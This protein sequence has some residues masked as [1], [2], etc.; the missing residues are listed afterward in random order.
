LCLLPL[1]SLCL[2]GSFLYAKAP[3]QTIRVGSKAFPESLILGELVAQLAESPSV[4]ARHRKSLGGTR[5]L[6]EA[7]VAG[8]IDVYPE[9]TGT[10]SEE[11]LSGKGIRG[12][13]AIRQALATDAFAGQDLFANRAGVLGINVDI[14]GH[15]RFP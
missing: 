6:W 14:A 2:C 10:I 12:E 3:K 15:E 11:I 5:V 1:C 4:A 7:L 13:E 8:D 9:Y